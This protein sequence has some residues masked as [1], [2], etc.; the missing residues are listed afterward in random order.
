MITG[1][2]IKAAPRAGLSVTLL[3]KIE[4]ATPTDEQRVGILG[5]LEA[6]GIDFTN[7]D[8]PGVKLEVTSA[9]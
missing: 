2:Q 6:A 3:S 5:A 9:K 4:D 1:A 7:G 8:E